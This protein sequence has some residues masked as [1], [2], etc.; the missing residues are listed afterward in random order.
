[1]TLSLAKNDM[2]QM[3]Y[4]SVV[5][6]KMAYLTA[7]FPIVCLTAQDGAEGPCSFGYKVILS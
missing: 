7:F 4:A 1:M 2:D 3:G 6:Y 5:L